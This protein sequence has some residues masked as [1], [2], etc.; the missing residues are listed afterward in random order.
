[1]KKAVYLRLAANASRFNRSYRIGTLMSSATLIATTMLL[2]S[3]VFTHAAILEGPITNLANGH[4]YYL[5]TTSTWTAA[6]AEARKLG[7]NLAA[8]DDAE[9]HNWLVSTFIPPNQPDRSLWIGLT[10][11]NEEGN[12]V[13]V[14]G[15]SSNY[16]RWCQNE[17]NN[18]CG[19][20]NFIQIWQCGADYRWNDTFDD[21]VPHGG[22]AVHGVVEVDRNPRPVV[23]VASVAVRWFATSNQNYQVQ[24]RSAATTNAWTDWGA[25]VVGA[26]T[27]VVLFDSVFDV[28]KRFYR[29]LLVE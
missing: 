23:E 15:S 9:E 28:P 26:G 3:Q 27:N 24:Y 20:E 10:D 5:L 2:G 18:C 6:Q 25:R 17:P 22:A 21:P 29:V 7:G 13:W 19:G 4:F 1:M 16:R 11:R 14:D 8:I 12:F